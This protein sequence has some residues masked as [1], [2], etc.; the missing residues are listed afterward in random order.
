[1]IRLIDKPK[2][3][4]IAFQFFFELTHRVIIS[5]FVKKRK[6]NFVIDQHSFCISSNLY[7]LSLLFKPNF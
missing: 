4:E 7:R 3:S 6:S 2:F 5:I 1:M